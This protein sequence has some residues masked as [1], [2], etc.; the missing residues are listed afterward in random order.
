MLKLIIL[1]FFKINMIE[2]EQVHKLSLFD[3]LSWIEDIQ[4]I[5]Y[6]WDVFFIA[7]LILQD[8]DIKY[9]SELIKIL[10][11]PNLWSLY[12]ERAIKNYIVSQLPKITFEDLID[13]LWKENLVLFEY[14]YKK[15]FKTP[16]EQ[17]YPYFQN[18]PTEIF[19]YMVST[20]LPINEAS[21]EVINI[22][23][24]TN[25][26]LV[27]R[28]EIYLKLRF[29]NTS[30]QKSLVSKLPKD[31]SKVIERDSNY[32]NSPATSSKKFKID[33]NFKN[34]L[35]NIEEDSKKRAIVFYL[36]Y[37][38][39]NEDFKQI[40][41]EIIDKVKFEIKSW[42]SW[43]EKIIITFRYQNQYDKSLIELIEDWNDIIKFAFVEWDEF[44]S[45]I[46]SSNRNIIHL[47]DW[48]PEELLDTNNWTS[49]I[50]E[51]TI[52]RFNFQKYWISDFIELPWSAN[53][54]KDMD[55]Y[56][57]INTFMDCIK[58]LTPNNKNQIAQKVQ[59]II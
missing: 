33:N 51:N 36:R 12:K 4:G 40:I 26:E 23:L 13:F 56:W 22:L 39:L 19:S 15:A 50:N 3:R 8:S 20:A 14:L 58:W 35:W 9:N 30:D 7:K 37:G 21:D 27:V 52:D 45:L 43:F 16:F 54:P 17:I 24:D 18:T 25:I 6:Q 48:T 32:Q 55:D 2:S 10:N 57:Y 11:Y 5:N 34:N 41:K 59:D 1:A 38:N 31:L 42:N 28:Y 29:T 44:Q 53:Q 46:N 47:M 49:I